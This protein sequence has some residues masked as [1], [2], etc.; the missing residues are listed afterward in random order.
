MKRCPSCQSVF[1]DSNDFCLNDGTALIVDQIS[2][3]TVVL[4]P[5]S[6][7]PA[8][9]NASQPATNTTVF[10]MFGVILMLAVTTVGLAVAYFMSNS[11]IGQSAETSKSESKT[12][13]SPAKTVDETVPQRSQPTLPPD[14]RLVEENERLRTEAERNR[15]QPV[16]APLGSRRALVRRPPTNIR[17][18]PGR[19]VQCI[20]R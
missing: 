13:A 6:T 7:Q 20:I 3:P 4:T 8:A 2:Q 18:G 17:I 19:D 11:K 12:E 10:V 15:R 9:H 14:R 16:A 1:D 5:R